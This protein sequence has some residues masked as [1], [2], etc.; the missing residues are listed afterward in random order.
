MSY[1]RNL[2]RTITKYGSDEWNTLPTSNRIVE[3]LSEHRVLIQ[4]ELD[5]VNAGRR[6]LTDKSFLGPK[7]RERRR[8]E[9][10]QQGQ[11][12]ESEE[13]RKK[14]FEYFDA[15]EREHRKQKERRVKEA[16]QKRQAERKEQRIKDRREARQNLR[17]PTASSENSGRD[18][19]IN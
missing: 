11:E 15:M 6:K 2:N 8:L 5:E 17:N 9:A 1:F 10:I 18:A 13:Q 14:H 19:L 12:V 7:E 3:L 16:Q 4:T